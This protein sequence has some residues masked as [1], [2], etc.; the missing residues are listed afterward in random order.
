MLLICL[1]REVVGLASRV[2]P[3]WLLL[4]HCNFFA[5]DISDQL[6]DHV[7]FAREAKFIEL[8][9]ASGLISQ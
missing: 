3:R 1:V 7:C 5:I 2:A 6:I 8:R 9:V 4:G